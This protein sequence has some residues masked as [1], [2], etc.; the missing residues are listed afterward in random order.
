MSMAAKSKALGKGLGAIF[1]RDNVSLDGPGLTP[2]ELPIDELSPNPYQPRRKFDAEALAELA[3]SIKAHG[4]LQPI[5][6]RKKDGAYQ[7]IAGERRWRAAKAAGLSTIPA[8]VK[9][10]DDSSMMQVA[11]I[12]NLQREDLNPIEEAVA[13]RKLMDEFGL[14]QEELSTAVGKSRPVIAN[15]VR[16]LNLPQQVQDQLAE[17]RI[18][19]GHARCLLTLPGA[20]LQTSLA[21]RIVKDGLNVRQTEQLVRRLTEN[22]SRE[23]KRQ[24]K[25]EVQDPDA[26]LLAGRLSER[27]GTKVKL[28]GTPHKGVIQ[29]EFYAAEDLDRILE[30]ILGTAETVRA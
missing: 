25:R 14:T 4:V 30:I 22:V 28:T 26:A 8:L 11:L 23:T 3:D 13:Y 7:I 12:E 21:D 10:M 19:A 27:L 9:Q 2:V 1:Q 17:G 18:T 16:L 20:Q 24:A 5:V 29:I 6:V 15:A